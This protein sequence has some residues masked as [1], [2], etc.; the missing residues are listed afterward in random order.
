M[1]ELFTRVKSIPTPDVVRVTRRCYP[2][3]QKL[4]KKKERYGVLLLPRLKAKSI[5]H[6]V[7]YYA[8]PFAGTH[9]I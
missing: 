1:S 3:T 7:W 4:M 6:Y 5:S 2:E 8:P 9:L